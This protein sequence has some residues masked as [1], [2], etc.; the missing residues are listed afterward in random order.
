MSL[1]PP[2]LAVEIRTFLSQPQVDLDTVSAKQIRLHLATVFPELDIKTLKQPIDE[3]S[4]PI[5]Y[6]VCLILSL[7][8][9]EAVSVFVHSAFARHTYP[10]FSTLKID[11]RGRRYGCY[12]GATATI[13]P[14]PCSTHPR[15]PRR[16]W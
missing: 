15:Y 10:L 11:Q 8:P 12:Q 16:G 5:F 7:W 3:I 14:S 6:E 13:S 2:T 1:L 9:S 4:I